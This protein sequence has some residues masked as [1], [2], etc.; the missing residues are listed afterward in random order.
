[1][2]AAAGYCSKYFM[3]RL[4]YLQ[5]RTIY[6]YYSYSCTTIPASA[7]LSA[8]RTGRWLQVLEI[9]TTVIL[10]C[11]IDEFSCNKLYPFSRSQFHVIAIRYNLIVLYS[12]SLFPLISSAVA[13]S[14]RDGNTQS[15]QNIKQGW[16]YQIGIGYGTGRINSHPRQYP[17][18]LDIPVPAN[19]SRQNLIPVPV[20]PTGTGV[21]FREPIG[22][23]NDS[24]NNMSFD[25]IDQH[26]LNLS[27]YK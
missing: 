10:C 17:K 13:I 24:I 19:S 27:P 6:W 25:H 23:T 20:L 7:G 4:D 2:Q 21:G 26:I 15:S 3:Q 12:S 11:D 18:L 14:N 16:Q 5:T 1:M 9:I 8:S 22:S